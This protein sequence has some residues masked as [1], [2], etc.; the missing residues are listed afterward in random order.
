MKTTN[1]IITAFFLFVIG[2]NLVLFVSGK[3][4]E[5]D[6]DLTSREYFLDDVSINVVVAEPD[7]LIRIHTFE[8][9]TVAIHYPVNER[10]PE[11]FYR[12]SNDTLYVSRMILENHESRRVDLYTKN[13]TSVVAKS[14]SDIRITSF[15]SD[16][17]EISAEQARIE[18]NNASLEEMVIHAIHSNISMYSIHKLTYVFAKLENESALRTDSK[19]IS[20]IDVEKDQSSRYNAY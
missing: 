14:N 2:C 1:Y 19:N 18:I 10:E 17:L 3:S 20:K 15:F 9:N 13:I 16:N 6:D 7:A 8:A 5:N 11:K 12:V 4:H